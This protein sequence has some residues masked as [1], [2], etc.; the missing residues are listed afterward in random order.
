MAV[1]HTI[2]N[3]QQKN[4][5]SARGDFSS[6]LDDELM[7]G[8]TDLLQVG[9]SENLVMSELE[10]NFDM[11]DAINKQKPDNLPAL[12]YDR[13]EIEKAVH[14]KAEQQRQQEQEDEGILSSSC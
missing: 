3:N 1:P 7:Y 9:M 11:I 8:A 4:R 6:E 12:E 10:R 2:V 14:E 13:E 5:Y